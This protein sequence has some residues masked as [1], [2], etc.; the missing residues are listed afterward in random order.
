VHRTTVNLDGVRVRGPAS[1][2]VTLVEFSDFHCPFCKGVEATLDQVRSRYGD[3]VRLVFKDFP[4]DSLHPQSR[5]AHEAARCADEQGKFW[6]Y[7]T[8]L[9]AGNPKTPDQLKGVAQQVGLDMAKYDQCVASGKHRAAVQKEIDEG[10]RLG[11]TGTPAFFIN[12]RLLSGAQPLASFTRL[13]D[14]ELS[15]V[16]QP[17]AAAR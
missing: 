10:R 8:V 14:D 15:R 16:A 4:I 2:P 13:I 11:V 9:F 6:E 17:T 1:A 5:P 12:G 3:K 7:H